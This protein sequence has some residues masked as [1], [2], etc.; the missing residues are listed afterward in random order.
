VGETLKSLIRSGLTTI[1]AV[2]LAACSMPTPEE[3]ALI[4]KA[5]IAREHAFCAFE[6]LVYEDTGEFGYRYGLIEYNWHL[7]QCIGRDPK[8][9]KCRENEPLFLRYPNFLCKTRDGEVEAI[10][11]L[12][13]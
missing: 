6:N 11:Y 12:Q 3:L 7:T 13:V 5:Y 10:E 4:S 8:P 1:V 2:L 9:F